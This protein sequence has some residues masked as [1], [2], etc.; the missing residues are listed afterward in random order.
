MIQEVRCLGK[1][2]QCKVLTKKLVISYHILTNSLRIIFQEI[3]GKIP[4]K[5]L[6]TSLHISYKFTRQETFVAKNP[7][8]GIFP[9]SYKCIK[10]HFSRNNWQDSCQES[11]HIFAHFLQVYQARNS[12]NSCQESCKESCG[13]FPYSYKCTKDHFSRNN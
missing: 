2:Q 3:A 8:K 4:V 6:A 7:V 9:Y 1:T 5:N 13:I 12:C 11:Y 10:H